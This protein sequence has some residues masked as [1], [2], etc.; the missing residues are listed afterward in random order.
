MLQYG[1]WCAIFTLRPD[2]AEGVSKMT[3]L[4][5]ISAEAVAALRAASNFGMEMDAATRLPDGTY[6]LPLRN[7]T[8]ARLVAACQ[9][10]EAPSDF[11]VRAYAVIAGQVN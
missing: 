1:A 11:I 3:T 8:A 4:V 9:P 10:G 2:P 7:E 5:N 6:N